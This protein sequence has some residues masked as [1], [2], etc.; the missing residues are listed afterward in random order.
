[1]EEKN[2]DTATSQKEDK[3][4]RTRS[5]NFPSVTLRVAVERT[6]ALY[7]NAETHKVPLATAAN[8]WGY[9]VKSSG[10]LKLL[11]ALGAY[12]LVEFEGS[13]DTRRIQVSEDGE[14]IVENA[15]GYENIL[16]KSAMRP[17][18]F[19]KI[20]DEYAPNGRLPSDDI[21]KDSLRWDKKIEL[22]KET[23][24]KFV[25]NLKETIT[26]AKLEDEA[27]IAPNEG[28]EPPASEENDKDSKVDGQLDEPAL[29]TH[30]GTY[31]TGTQKMKQYPIPLGGGA[32]AVLS[33][34]Q[35]ITA[36]MYE[37]LKTVIDL[38]EDVLVS[39]EEPDQMSDELD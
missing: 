34:P 27:I 32:D 28:E 9:S 13:G 1:M 14:R 22:N 11:A 31:Q 23:I 17:K 24:D 7:R 20:M 4:K 33:I 39:K 5:P 6:D 12:G 25:T 26:Y 15:P 2:N 30:T 29:G 36:R 37:K 21:L 8:T 19:G 18:L 38:Y 16:K 35:P 10:F 3:R